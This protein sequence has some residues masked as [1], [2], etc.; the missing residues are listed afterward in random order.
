M[1]GLRLEATLLQLALYDVTRRVAVP[2]IGGVD[3]LRVRA[4]RHAP[5]AGALVGLGGALALWLGAVVLGP[6]VGAMLSLIVV[7]FMTRGWGWRGF[8]ATFDALAS[9]RR[10][11]E[12]LARM[13][14]PGLDGAGGLALV[15]GI[16]LYAAL[17]S[18]LPAEVA[19]VALIT[20]LGLGQMA[21]VHVKATTLAVRREGMKAR[22]FEVTDDGYRMAL[23]QTLLL[24]A[25]P[26]LVSGPAAGL[27]AGLGAVVSGQVMRWIF[28]TRLGGYTRE[29]LAAV[30]ICAELGAL[31][32]IALVA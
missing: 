27:A 30:Q 18:G 29:G 10:R 5:L 9:G 7:V 12:V 8:A 28:V 1:N 24:C 21:R 20:V 31:L 26:V 23:A 19:G 2:R 11:T 32:G 14:L 6:A 16:G 3:D 22:L 25:G 15:L 17:L 13:S 4:L